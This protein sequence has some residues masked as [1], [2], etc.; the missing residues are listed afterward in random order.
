MTIK[1]RDWTLES[2]LWAELS[3]YGER[4]TFGPREVGFEDNAELRVW[5]VAHLGYGVAEII[6][7]LNDRAEKVRS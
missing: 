6:N 1:G 7:L 2:L 3:Y 5:F 4:L